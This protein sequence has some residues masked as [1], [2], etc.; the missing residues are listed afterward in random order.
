TGAPS[1]SGRIVFLALGGTATSELLCTSSDQNPPSFA[2]THPECEPSSYFQH[3]NS[4][5]GEYND[6]ARVT[7]V[8][9]AYP[10]QYA[11]N[12]SQ[13]VTPAFPPI[14]ANAGIPTVNGNYDRIRDRVLT[15]YALHPVAE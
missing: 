8:N 3:A 10:N 13:N 2:G 1:A 15:G 6:R 7:I 14:P 4:S 11:E 5:P 12:F 9:G